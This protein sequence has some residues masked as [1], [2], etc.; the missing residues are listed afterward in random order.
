MAT[1]LHGLRTV[2]YT[3]TDL[4][5]TKEWYSKAFGIEPYFD[6]VFYVG[7]N[8]GGY[9]LGLHPAESTPKG[10]GY[11]GTAYWG[12]DDAEAAYNNLIAAGATALEKPTEVGGGIVVATVADPWGNSLG[13][14]YN[15]HFKL[16]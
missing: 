9:E 2:V 11:G 6:E 3:T 5:A 13:I 4:Q 16:P 14:I 7:F 1:N 15:P 12:V 10:S 8:V